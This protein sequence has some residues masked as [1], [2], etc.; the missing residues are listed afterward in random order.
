MNKSNATILALLLL[1]NHG[2][3]WSKDAD[4]EPVAPAIDTTVYDKE[5]IKQAMII[6]L[7]SRTV[8]VDP[9]KAPRVNPKLIEEL[10]RDGII[11]PAEM[12]AGVVC[13]DTTGK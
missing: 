6:L 3:A 13:V 1:L 5:T 11:Q 10:R 4:N 12:R 9:S 8:T 2:E 7:K